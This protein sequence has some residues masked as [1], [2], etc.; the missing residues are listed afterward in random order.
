MDIP[1]LLPGLESLAHDIIL[2]I[3]APAAPAPIALPELPPVELDGPL[4]DGDVNLNLGSTFGD[5]GSTFGDFGST[6]GDANLG[7][8]GL[9]LPG[10]SAVDAGGAA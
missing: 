5:M 8:S 2:N 10:S 4:V 6:M 3:P 7:S 9:E 1:S